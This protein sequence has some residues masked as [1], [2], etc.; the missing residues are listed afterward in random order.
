MK[1]R[2]TFAALTAALAT[3]ACTPQSDAPTQ[4]DVAAETTETAAPNALERP[5]IYLD[6]I[7][8]DIRDDVFYFVMPDRFYN[9]E[10]ANDNGSVD[11][12]ISQGGY[13]PTSR[14]GFHGGDMQGLEAKLD[15]L[16]EMGITAIWMTPILRN[17]AIQ[18]SSQAHHGYWI[19]DF[20]QIDPHFGSNDALRSLKQ[21][22]HKRGIK[23]FFDIITNHTAD[24]IKYEECHQPDGSFLPGNS[25]CK[26]KSSEQLAQGDKYTPFIPAGEENVKTPAWLNDPK[27]YN[28]QGDSFWQGESAIKGDFVGL[29]DIDTSQP[30]VVS[31]FIDIYKNIISEFKPDGFRVDTVKHVDMS[32]WQEFTPAIIE[33]AKAEGIPNFH[34]FGEVYSGDPMVL[35]SFTTTG[36][37]PSV[38]DFGFQEAVANVVYRD[39]P[40]TAIQTLFDNDDYYSD[41]DSQADLLMNFLGNHDMGRAGFFI[42]QGMGDISE[43]EKLKRMNLS[44]A[45]MYLSRGV[46]VVYYGDEQGFTGDGGDIDARENMFPSKVDSYNDNNLIGTD[47]TTAEDNFDTSHPI[48]REL[49]H[50]ASVRMAHKALRYGMSVNRYFDD[51][52]KVFA[53]S[54]VDKDEK[55]EYLAVFN[56]DTEAQSLSLPASADAYTFISGHQDFRVQ[57]GE[58]TVALPGL[59]Y[60]LLRA[61]APLP[62]SNNLEVKFVGNQLID[63]RNHFTFDIPAAKDQVV[64]MFQLAVELKG[65]V[66]GWVPV[67]FD[68]APPYRIIIDNE[69]LQEIGPKQMRLNVSNLAGQFSSQTISLVSRGKTSVD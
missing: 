47:A 66:G 65:D 41:A 17:K 58:V 64:P 42:E 9:G 19:L 3:M 20:T 10:P 27:Y 48:Y 59:S 14:F 36:N 40:T 46:P 31:G 34:V 18:G 49:R 6:A 68:H 53:L 51:S 32:F 69:K 13:D 11:I 25:E 26:F 50:L 8:R 15:Y 67:A 35:S 1:T 60:T 62:A 16:Q 56:T 2:L 7:N 63:G 21:A 39:Q 45:I 43:D 33:H 38:L 22:A 30:E 23:I 28:N 37:M 5:A 44:H 12:A 57:Q 55:V 54:R 24:V 52:S 4:Q 61:S 29:D